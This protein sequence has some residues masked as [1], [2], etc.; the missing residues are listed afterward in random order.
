MAGECTARTAQHTTLIAWC[1]VN[2]NLN[3]LSLPANPHQF[4]AH[5]TPPCHFL[6]CPAQHVACIA[7]CVPTC[8]VTCYLH[9]TLPVYLCSY[10]LPHLIEQDEVSVRQL[11]L[12]LV[13]RTCRCGRKCGK[14][15]GWCE[16]WC[17]GQQQVFCSSYLS[18]LF[19]PALLNFPLPPLAFPPPACP[20]ALLASLNPAPL[21]PLPPL[22]LPPPSPRPSPPPSP[23]PPPAPFPSSPS[24]P[25]HPSP[26]PPSPHP[27]VWAPSA[28]CQ[29]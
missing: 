13:H 12:R 24:P 28:A 20:P 23:P 17:E 15:C 9:N 18:P 3:S 6:S 1:E 19:P 7:T 11:D 5:N 27:W 22:P 21:P 26:P 2:I 25:H 4:H 16:T 8:V 14:K 29:C 10:L